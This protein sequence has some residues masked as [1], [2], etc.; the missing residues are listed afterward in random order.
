MMF[1]GVIAVK[2]EIGKLSIAE[3]RLQNPNKVI[4]IDGLTVRSDADQM[5]FKV[6]DGSQLIDPSVGVVQATEDTNFGRVSSVKIRGGNLIE[7]PGSQLSSLFGDT[8][9]DTNN[10]WIRYDC[11]CDRNIFPLKLVHGQSF[12]MHTATWNKNIFCCMVDW[13]EFN[14]K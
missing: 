14:L 10:H 5:V 2:A 9:E 4:L 8:Q 7:L 1:K 6:Y 13:R 12:A 3:L 11:H